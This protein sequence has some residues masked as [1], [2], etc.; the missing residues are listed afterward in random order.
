MKGVNN[1]FIESN[2]LIL[3]YFEIS[4]G[5]DLFEYLS[6]REVVEFEP[7]EPITLDMADEVVRS[8]TDNH[9]FIAVSLKDTNK[10]IGN[11]YVEKTEPEKVDTYEIGYV[12]NKKFHGKGYA[13]EA[14]ECLLNHLFFSRNAHRVVAYCNTQNINSWRLL[15][16]LKF[17]REAE[18]VENMYFNVSESGDP[19]WFNSYQ[20]ALLEHEFKQN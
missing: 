9:S 19:L 16:R 7:Y 15:E 10:L 17:R 2:R 3:R 5:D 8:R 20:Y 18:R 4:D 14:V 6:D 1:M 13:T 11:L 12:F